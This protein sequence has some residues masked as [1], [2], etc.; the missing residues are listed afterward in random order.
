MKSGTGSDELARTCR[1]ARLRY[2]REAKE[3]FGEEDALLFR[4]WGVGIVSLLLFFFSRRRVINALAV[5]FFQCSH[6]VNP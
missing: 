4:L 5:A 6:S 2:C 3:H 1:R